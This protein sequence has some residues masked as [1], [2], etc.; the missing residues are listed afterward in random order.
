M[1]KSLTFL[2]KF[3][4]MKCFFFMFWGIIYSLARLY[5]RSKEIQIYVIV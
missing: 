1:Y 5:A 2:L 4:E 3:K